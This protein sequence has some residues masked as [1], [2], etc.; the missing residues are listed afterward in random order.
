MGF[1]LNL[2]DRKVRRRRIL[3]VNLMDR[4][5]V[6]V[7]EMRKLHGKK[8][9]DCGRTDGRILMKFEGSEGEIETRAMTKFEEKRAKGGGEIEICGGERR[10]R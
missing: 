6:V 7:E 8:M 5:C 10:R 4:N 2:T 1:G 9:E 3:S